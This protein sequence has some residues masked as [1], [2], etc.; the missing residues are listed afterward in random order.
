MALIDAQFLHYDGDVVKEE[1]VLFFFRKHMLK[2]IGIQLTLQ[3]P[4][5][6]LPPGREAGGEVT[7]QTGPAVGKGTRMMPDTFLAVFLLAE[8]S[9]FNT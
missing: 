9:N 5:E 7:E 4:R 2:Y 6:N 1:N 3:R 8:V